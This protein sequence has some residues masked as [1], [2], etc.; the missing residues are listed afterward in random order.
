MNQHPQTIPDLILFNQL[1]EHYVRLEGRLRNIAADMESLDQLIRAHY[2]TGAVNHT[3]RPGDS[4]S[5][6][7][8][9]DLG[10]GTGEQAAVLNHMGYAVHGIDISPRMIALAG[11]R[12]GRHPRL[13][14]Q[15]GDFRS[16]QQA[17]GFA[18]G[19]SLFGCLNYL[20]QDTDLAAVFQNATA[21]LKR[22]GILILEVWHRRPYSG[23]GYTYQAPAVVLES[24]GESIRRRRRV[25]RSVRNGRD[26]IQIHYEYE[27]RT[28]HLREMH[29][30]RL[31][32]CEEITRPAQAAGFTLLDVRGS[33]GES[34]FDR[35]RSGGMVLVL[36]AP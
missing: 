4:R 32:D 2:K 20:H 17:R 21:L 30:F 31:F 9:I 34:G 29:T 27:T 19:Y 6:I 35:K 15:L 18:A 3:T 33:L 7:D 28:G 11:Q 36:R 10:C 22:S 12:F 14:F 5:D 23:L 25:E 8:L 16:Y 26:F 1:A 24:S 13:S